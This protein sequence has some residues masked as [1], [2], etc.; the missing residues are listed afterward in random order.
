MAQAYRLSAAWNGSLSEL[1]ATPNAQVLDCLKRFLPKVEKDDPQWKAWVQEIEIL[2][3]ID[4]AGDDGIILEYELP[5]QGGRR[6]DVVVLQK[7]RVIVLEFKGTDQLLRADIDQVTAYARDLKQYHS[8]CV[9]QRVTP[10]LVLCG[11][12]A[13]NAEVDGVRVVPAD[14]L[15]QCL[16]ELGAATSGTRLDR[17][18]FLKGTYEPLPT[19]VAAA[20]LL[21]ENGELPYIRRAASAGVHEAVETVV[22]LAKSAEENGSKKLVLVTGVPGAGKTLV[23]LQVAHS[24]AFSTDPGA[25]AVFLSGNRPLV[26]VLQDALD[27]KVFVQPLHGY[28]EEYGL[29]HPEQKPKERVLV[30]DE[31][32]RAWDQDK[33]AYRYQKEFSDVI[34]DRPCSEPDLLTEIAGR[35]ELEEWG[36]VL[37][38]VGHGQEI[39]TGEEG[40]MMLWADAIRRSNILWEVH[41]PSTEQDLFE[42]K[43]IDFTVDKALGLNETLRTHAAK[44]LHRWVSLVLDDESPR[45]AQPLAAELRPQGFPIYVTRDVE[46][47]REYV[48]SRRSE[49][50]DDPSWRCGLLASSKAHKLTKYDIDPGYPARE[51]VDIA[52][53]FNDGLENRD[54]DGLD[55]LVAGSHMQTVISEFECQGLELDL[56]IVCWGDDFWWSARKWCSKPPW[57]KPQTQA[58]RPQMRDPHGLR[59]NVYRVLLTRGREG[60]VIFV[61]PEPSEKMDATAK[62]LK[63]AGA[64]EL[65]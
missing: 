60:M 62:A 56:P 20:R 12:G 1:I 14:Q 49:F 31:A 29:K 10:I 21:F 3:R 54:T 39:H 52:R 59:T 44:N 25:R 65:E 58:K 46:D 16:V 42:G 51:E 18:D 50:E 48:R 27:N 30:F 9:E 11:Q 38:L 23:G 63:V 45:N 4:S 7:G 55:R 26:T 13:E 32:Q 5:R 40:G 28:I 37:A 43:G 22:E 19:L 15:G 35:L 53:W 64:V 36:L 24:A 2:Q 61:P 34:A 17:R 41:G 6:P 57:Q 47:A 8:A 33:V